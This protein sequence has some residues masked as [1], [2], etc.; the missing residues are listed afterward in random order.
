MPRSGTAALLFTTTLLV[1]VNINNANANSVKKLSISAQD[2]FNQAPVITV[3][4]SNGERW[5]KVDKTKI[6]QFSINLKA[7]CKYEGK[8]N[9]AYKGRMSVSGF[10]LVGDSA[11]PANF[12]IPHSNEASG[13]YSYT[14]GQNLSPSEVCNDELNKRLSSQPTLSKYHILAKGLNVNYPAAFTV[15]YH[16]T[17][18]PT[19]LGFTDSA[20]KTTQVNAKIACLASAIAETK[21]PKPKPKTATAMLLPLIK[22]IKFKATPSTYKGSCP[23]GIKFNGSISSNNAGTVKYRYVSHDAKVSPTFT[24]KF[25]KASTLAVRNWHRTVSKP[26]ASSTL[27]VKGASS[28]NT[29]SGWYRLEVLTPDTKGKVTAKYQVECIEPT[30]SRAQIKNEPLSPSHE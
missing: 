10:S 27:A 21:I 8:G 24:L 7:E 5:D 20:S 16:L 30:P 22:S 17:C 26:E 2:G 28:N 3:Y 14:Q 15:G 25:N 18:K 6:S 13:N 29:I 19:G 1:A 4:S 11:E 23:S 12:L 9:K